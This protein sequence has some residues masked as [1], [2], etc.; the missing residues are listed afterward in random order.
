[1]TEPAAP[2]TSPLV[3]QDLI[4]AALVGRTDAIDRV[5]V[6]NTWAT[7]PDK[8]PIVLVRYARN[9]RRAQGKG[10]LAFT[11]VDVVQ[12]VLQV[13]RLAAGADDEILAAETEAWRI[14]RQLEVAIVGYLPLTQRLEYF[15]SMNSGINRNSDGQQTIVEIHTELALQYYQGAEHFGLDYDGEEVGQDELPELQEVSIDLLQPRD[16]PG[17]GAIVVTVG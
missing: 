3:L 17:P 11:A 14:Q 16:D 4:K 10:G 13:A 9:D 1:M 8:M 5:F 6:P 12:L 7:R 2:L 15:P